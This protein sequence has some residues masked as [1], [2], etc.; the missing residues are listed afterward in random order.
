MSAAPVF[1]PSISFRNTN[2]GWVEVPDDQGI[3]NLTGSRSSVLLIHGYNNTEDEATSSYTAFRDIQASLGRTGTRFIGVYWPGDN[4]TKGAYYMAAVG[5]AVVSAQQLAAALRQA[6][7]RVGQLTLSIVCHS[8]GARLTLELLAALQGDPVHGLI[9]DRIVFMAAAVA[10]ERLPAA[11]RPLG[12]ALN[13]FAQAHGITR[14]L[15]S[16]DDQVLTWAFPL[17]ETLTPGEDIILPVAL[18]HQKWTS[19]NRP[20][21]FDQQPNNG[22]NHGDYWGGNSDPNA[23]QFAKQAGTLVN[24][25][26]PPYPSPLRSV[27][28]VVP[29]VR[30]GPPARTGGEA[31]TVGARQVA[32]R[33]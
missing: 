27:P 21:N 6:V 25:F 29:T 26:L 28:A 23:L 13:A 11:S 1:T 10:V 18:G 15:H 30:S 4:W 24:Q 32:G 17:G 7:E 9:I 16:S 20:P 8:L 5:K 19:P 12:E 31:R 22:A 14:S 3:W 33:A 2:G